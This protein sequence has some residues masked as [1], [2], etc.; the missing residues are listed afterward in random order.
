MRII[1][2]RFLTV[3]AITCSACACALVS[4]ARADPGNGTG[5]VA[6]G[7]LVCTSPAGATYSM[8][9][10]VPGAQNAAN[11]GTGAA[12]APFPGF[13]VSYSQLSGPPAPLPTGTWQLLAFPTGRTIGQRTGLQGDEFVDCGIAPTGPGL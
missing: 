8:T 11:R 10:V 7:T 3:A 4:S 6:L 12:N 13:L 9:F 2:K 1:R 5:L